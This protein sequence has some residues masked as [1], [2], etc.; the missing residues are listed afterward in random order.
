MKAFPLQW[1]PDRPRTK[2]REEARFG[3][4]SKKRRNLDGTHSYQTQTALT[5]NQAMQRLE[6]EMERSGIDMDDVVVSSNLALRLDGRP[7]SGQ[8][9]PA[10]P[11][12][13]VYFIRKGQTV[14]FANDKYDRVADCIA[15]VAKTLE[16]LR[17]IARWGTADEANRAFTGFTPL[18][19]PKTWRDILG[20][21]PG[22]HAI[23]AV[24]S[25]YRQKANKLH[26]DKPGGSHDAIVEINLARK[27][28]MEELN[29]ETGA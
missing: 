19:P 20:L 5:V 9:E 13:A 17:G 14:C 21:G 18:P 3:N 15:A 4:A 2:W 12:V 6:L 27:A 28:A 22:A 10:D 7:R 29:G 1:P 23:A 16:A 26:P 24:E 11:G 25:A 8:A